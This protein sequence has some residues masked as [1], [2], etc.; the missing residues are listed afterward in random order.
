MDS[1][2][3]PLHGMEEVEAPATTDAT[4][5]RP[6]TGSGKSPMQC[7]NGRGPWWNAGASHLNA[8]LPTAYFRK[9]GLI[10]LME[11]VHWLTLKRSLRSS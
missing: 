2:E 6:G 4:V 7:L 5:G 11:E 3:T 9:L 1:E 8:A 10:S